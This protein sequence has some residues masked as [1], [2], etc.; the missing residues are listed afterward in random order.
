ML[1]YLPS[2]FGISFL[3]VRTQRGT[4]KHT[5]SWRKLI[6]WSSN[7]SAYIY[8][9]WFCQDISHSLKRIGMLST[10]EKKERKKKRQFNLTDLGKQVL[11]GPFLKFFILGLGITTHSL[12]A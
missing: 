4:W 7:I 2:S 5:S 10:R 11:W 3:F 9:S 8:D 6:I 1:V 12:L